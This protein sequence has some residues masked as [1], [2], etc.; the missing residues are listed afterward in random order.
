MRRAGGVVLSLAHELSPVGNGPLYPRTRR[1]FGT[2][3]SHSLHR[4]FMTPYCK[5]TLSH[6]V[7]P[8][9]NTQWSGAFKSFPGPGEHTGVRRALGQVAATIVVVATKR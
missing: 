9:R 1:D 2:T 8:Q 4:V 7:R 3:S 6:K 5:R